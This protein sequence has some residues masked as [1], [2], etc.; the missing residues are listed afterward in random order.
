MKSEIAKTNYRIMSNNQFE[1]P[2]EPPM[3]VRVAYAEYFNDEAAEREEMKERKELVGWF[4]FATYVIF[5]VYLIVFLG[6]KINNQQA[7]IDSLKITLEELSAI[8][9]QGGVQVGL[10]GVLPSGVLPCEIHKILSKIEKIDK[11]RK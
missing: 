3:G 6:Q 10:P 8:H 2:Q 7:Q 9:I 11:T 5:C 4:L 1:E